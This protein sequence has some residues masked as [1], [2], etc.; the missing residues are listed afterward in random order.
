MEI[1]SSDRERERE[2]EK[3]MAH[4]CIPQ[5]REYPPPGPNLSPTGNANCLTMV[6]VLIGCCALHV[7][8]KRTQ[9]VAVNHLLLGTAMTMA[10]DNYEIQFK[11][12]LYKRFQICQKHLI[13]KVEYFNTIEQLKFA[14]TDEPSKS[15]HG[16]YN[17]QQVPIVICSFLC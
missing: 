11:E 17:T 1:F 12:E 7:P 6:T 13:P 14:A 4:T 9:S 5:Y 16:Y 10:Q 15:H 8:I 3:K 2:R